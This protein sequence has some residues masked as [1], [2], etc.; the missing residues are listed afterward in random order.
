MM[1]DCKSISYYLYIMGVCSVDGLFFMSFRV[2]LMHNLDAESGLA[3]AMEEE[4]M[5]SGLL[6]PRENWKFGGE[7][8]FPPKN[9]DFTVKSKSQR[10]AW[11]S[12]SVID[13][14]KLLT[15]IPI[16]F[17]AAVKVHQDDCMMSK[18]YIYLKGIYQ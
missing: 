13:H 5:I 9:V 10:T 16:L 2:C 12:V 6:F 1:F 7:N 18:E 4:N 17:Q 11:F 8:C 15:S 14:V 3:L